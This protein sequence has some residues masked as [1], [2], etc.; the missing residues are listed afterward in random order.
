MWDLPGLGSNPW[1][2]HWQTDFQPLGHWGNPIQPSL[3]KNFNLETQPLFLFV[4]VKRAIVNFFFFFAKMFRYWSLSK[5]LLHGTQGEWGSSDAL[6]GL[7][8]YWNDMGVLSPKDTEG[9][10][11]SSLIKGGFKCSWLACPVGPCLISHKSTERLRNSRTERMSCVCC[12]F[13]SGS[14]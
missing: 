9:P 11:K 4:V 1:P 7:F 6:L 14:K 5:V 2:L 8:S 13:C 3:V 10:S 12:C